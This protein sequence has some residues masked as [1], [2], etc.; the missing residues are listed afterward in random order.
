MTDAYLLCRR[1][2]VLHALGAPGPWRQVDEEAAAELAA[3]RALHEAHGLERGERIE[4][5]AIVDG[6]VSDPMATRWFHI[7]VGAERLTVRSWRPSIELPRR[8]ELVENGP[9]PT[10]AR[11]DVDEPLL[12]RALDR[13]FYPHVIR[14]AQIDA[15]IAAV[16][17][18]VGRL[19]PERVETAFDDADLPDTAIGPFPTELGAALLERVQSAFDSV[20]M[21]RLN[22]FV[23]GHSR[24]DGAL[25]LRVHRALAP[26]AA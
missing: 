5:R 14:S 1:C 22:A 12:R 19:D 23:A 17:E 11:V 15:C 25:A 9:P 26:R 8:A 24:E 13:H 7:A 4:E 2:L 20:E 3:F 10:C 18:L 6:P 21:E 16:R